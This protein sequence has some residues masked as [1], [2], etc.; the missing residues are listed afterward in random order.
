[1]E[2][3]AKVMEYRTVRPDAHSPTVNRLLAG[4]LCESAGYHT[5]RRKGTTD[6][7]VIHTVAGRGRFGT[8]RGDIFA[9]PGTTTLLR[10]GTPHDYGVE[11]DLL[12]WELVW[13]HFHPRADWLALLAWPEQAPG[14]RQLHTGGDVEQRIVATLREAA[15]FSRSGM[16]LFAFNCLEAALLWCDSQNPLVRRMDER[17]LRVVDHVD[18]R[19]REPLSVAALAAVA[20]LSVSR[21]THLF[22]ANVGVS[23]QRYVERQRLNLATQL[24]DLTSRPVAAIAREVGF[25]DPLYFSTRFKHHTGMS[26]TAYRLRTR[27]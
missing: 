3:P 21:F 4:E 23:P 24:L 18:R 6:W 15:R 10:P 8:G 16:E 25:T 13:A 9:D 11:P 19:L 12:R 26:P 5:V 1:M 2:K 27:D 7:L 20:R 17:V 22:A 14:L